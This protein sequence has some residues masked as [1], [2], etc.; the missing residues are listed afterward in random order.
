MRSV[1]GSP[2]NELYDMLPYASKANNMDPYDRKQQQKTPH[3]PFSLRLIWLSSSDR[4]HPRLIAFPASGF[5]V[6]IGHGPSGLETSSGTRAPWVAEFLENCGG[7]SGQR[8]D[9][10]SLKS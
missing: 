10:K 1:E 4:D 8:V 3:L 6:E 2:R 5:G 7:Q 9:M